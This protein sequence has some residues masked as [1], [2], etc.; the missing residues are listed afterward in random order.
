MVILAV[1]VVLW[2]AMALVIM[3]LVI[4]AT[5]ANAGPVQHGI[6]ATAKQYQ[7]TLTR[8]TQQEWGLGAGVAR[9]AAQIH[10][11]SAW[12]GQAVS[13]AG[14]QGWAQ[15]M[16]ATAAWIAQIY[17]DLGPVAPYSPAW[18]FRAMARYDGWLWARHQGHTHC[19]RWWLTLRAYNGGERN[20]RRE[21]ANAADPLDRAAVDAACGSARRPAKHCPENTGYPRHILLELEPRYLAAGWRG[22]ATCSG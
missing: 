18:A 6:P 13:W 22:V 20:L 7:R 17:P 3:A 4:S 8:I 2:L 21:A 5:D 15:F 19:D 11:E 14:A 10:Q 12:R 9:A 16:P 1:S